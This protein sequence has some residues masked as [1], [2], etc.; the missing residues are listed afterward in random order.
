MINFMH[1]KYCYLFQYWLYIQ[2]HLSRKK[3]QT[4]WKTIGF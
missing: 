4:F 3:N 1:Q 2:R